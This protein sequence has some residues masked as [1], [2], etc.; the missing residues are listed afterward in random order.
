M[1]TFADG[2][3]WTRV[4]HREFIQDIFSGPLPLLNG[5]TTFEVAKPIP[6]A[7]AGDPTSGNYA[8]PADRA[9]LGPGFP[10]N[11]GC[12]ATFPW[13]SRVAAQFQEYRFMGLVFQFVSCSANALSSTNTS[14]GTVIMGTNYNSNQ[15]AFVRKQQMENSSYVNSARPASS[16]MH[17]IECDPSQ[18][19]LPLAYIRDN[20]IPITAV[21]PANPNPI[22]NDLR[23][24]DQGLFQIATIGCQADRINLGELWVEYDVLLVKPELDTSFFAGGLDESCS[25]VNGS[26]FPDSCQDTWSTWYD[27]GLVCPSLMPP[28]LQRQTGRVAQTARVNRPFG[29]PLYYGVPGLE[30][31]NTNL[32]NGAYSTSTTVRKPC[33]SESNAGEDKFTF[34]MA[35]LCQ[36]G[37]PGTREIN[38]LVFRGPQ[39]D[40]DF[41]IEFSFDWY[42]PDGPSFVRG[43]SGNGRTFTVPQSETLEDQTGEPRTGPLATAV[44]FGPVVLSRRNAGGCRSNGKIYQSMFTS[45][46]NMYEDTI[47]TSAGTITT[48]ARNMGGDSHSYYNTLTVQGLVK[49]NA[50]DVVSPALIGTIHHAD[51]SVESYDSSWGAICINYVGATGGITVLPEPAGAGSLNRRQE[52]T[53]FVPPPSETDVMGP[54][55]VATSYRIRAKTVPLDY[56]LA[57]AVHTFGDRNVDESRPDSRTWSEGPFSYRPINSAQQPDYYGQ[58]GAGTGGAGAGGMFTMPPMGNQ[59]VIDLT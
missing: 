49:Y 32:I 58:P 36:S 28:D 27:T 55:Y 29:N 39:I 51:G 24:S 4:K 47:V 33:L 56:A 38:A 23:M 21:S 3:Y 12:S 59:S 26:G 11:P 15:S 6:F 16:Q 34:S 25:A 9:A 42:V 45:V 41:Y 19:P 18:N 53:A 37:F 30:Q 8:K 52:L 35:A 54:D 14:L 43:L 46:P 20:Y 40:K 5:L 17:G 50:L 22:V 7:V 10:L 1:P 13:L 44:A 31:G 57:G 2:K 48:K